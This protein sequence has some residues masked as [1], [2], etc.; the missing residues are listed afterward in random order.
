[1]RAR[2]PGGQEKLFGELNPNRIV[3]L[4]A[5]EPM[6]PS[7]DCYLTPR[8]VAAV[9]KGTVQKFCQSDSVR[10]ARGMSRIGGAPPLSPGGVFAG[11]HRGWPRS[12]SV[13]GSG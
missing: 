7:R 2:F 8:M 9:V 12:P 6:R 13:S 1:M 10:P 5:L 4:L 11:T 3:E